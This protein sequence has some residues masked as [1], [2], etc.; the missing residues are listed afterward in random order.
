[1][2]LRPFQIPD[3][4]KTVEV[5]DR[6][7]KFVLSPIERSFGTTLG[8][9]FRR[10]LISSMQGS[11]ITSVR[12]DGVLHEFSTIDGV[13]EDLP[14]IL[15]NLKGVKIKLFEGF[16]K[17]INLSIKTKGPVYAKD[18]E[19]DGTFEI[20]NP[21]HLIATV[22]REDVELNIILGVTTGRGYVPREELPG[23]N[24]A[25]IGTIFI[26]ALYSPIE[27]VNF[28]VESIGVKN[29]E[30][31]ILEIWTDGRIKPDDAVTIAAAL[32]RDHIEPFSELREI[33]I[34][35]EKEEPEDKKRLKKI[36][37]I[38]IS[39]LELSVRAA[40]CLK[41]AGIET[42]RDLVQMTE[43][44]MLKFPNFGKKSLQ[45]LLGILKSYGLTFDME[46]SKL[47]GK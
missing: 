13:P 9:A 43:Q 4:V 39:E 25:P 14:H 37:D 31:L 29:R 32:L 16:K 42:L 19:S 47:E 26:D 17:E 33:I 10:T 35:R 36:L 3:K 30:K 6:Y 15:L 34:E 22:M 20:A 1:M 5:N 46:P 18:I 12:I 27:R 11:A 38:K 44:E 7:A 23:Y 40:N 21:E 41:T 24:R 45:E 28:K 2:K 8:N